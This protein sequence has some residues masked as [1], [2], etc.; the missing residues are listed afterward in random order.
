MMAI[1]AMPLADADECEYG[2]VEAWA[3]TDEDGEWGEWQNATVHQRLRI[4]EPFQV[5]I[6]VT[7]K[8]AGSVSLKLTRAGATVAY[9][10]VDGAAPIE[11]WIDN[12]DVPAKW[13]ETFTWKI[14]PT[15]NWTEG[16]AALNIE[17]QFHTSED[18]KFVDF[19]IIAAYIEPQEW[20]GGNRNDDDTGDNGNTTDSGNGGA[21]LPGFEGLMGVAAM[22]VALSVLQMRKRW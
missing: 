15:G 11:E 7:S 10:V 14:R 5:R 6:E 3:R 21:G 12:F 18:N 8:V 2:K 4:H 16:T 1:G 22:L 9:E 13:S 20:Q 19:T 17:G